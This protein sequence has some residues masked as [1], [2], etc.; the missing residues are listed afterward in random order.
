MTSVPYLSVI[1]WVRNDGYTDGYVERIRRATGFLVNQLNRHHVPAEIVVVEWNPP[2]DRPLMADALAGLDA[3]GYVSVRVVIVDGRFH[4]PLIG[5]TLKGMH[6]LNAANVGLRRAR[7]RFIVPKAI[8][9]FFTDCVIEHIARQQLRNDEVYRC[10]RYDV[11]IQSNEWLEWGDDELIERMAERVTFHHDRLVQSPEWG[12]RDLHT[13]ACGDF[14]LM[15]AVHWHS[16]RGFQDD[17]SVLCLDADSIVLHAAAARGVREVCWPDGCRVYKIRHDNVFAHRISEEWKDWQRHLDRFATKRFSPT[18]RIR[19]RMFLDYPRRRVRGID[20]VIGP[21]IE[22]N[23][24]M[25]ARRYARSDISLVTNSA[26]W[27]LAHERLLE[28][29]TVRADW[30]NAGD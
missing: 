14:T 21:S 18:T 30:D 19:L 16:I 12:M 17:P 6:V 1:G 29:T 8:D 26:D 20:G 22:R 2:P 24:V 5:S 28:R 7:G 11:T 15:D 23:F 9:T 25:K 27:G 13:N 10:D 3:G 4:R